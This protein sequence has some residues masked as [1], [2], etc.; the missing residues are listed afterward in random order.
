MRLASGASV[1]TIPCTTVTSGTL[2]G[3]GHAA[4]TAGAAAP[5]AGFGPLWQPQITTEARMNV[6]TLV[7]AVISTG[8]SAIEDGA[9]RSAVSAALLSHAAGRQVTRDI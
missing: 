3:C 4:G 1:T 9:V 7:I 2:S 6:R 8:H 5:A